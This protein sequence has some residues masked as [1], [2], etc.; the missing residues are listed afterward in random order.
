VGGA[1]RGRH[2]EEDCWAVKLMTRKRRG[3]IVRSKKTVGVML[4]P[5]L[6]TGWP[7]G[8]PYHATDR[9]IGRGCRADGAREAK[10]VLL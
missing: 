1:V 4:S 6:L 9:A 2:M 10:M 7:Y 8:P 5:Y 3:A